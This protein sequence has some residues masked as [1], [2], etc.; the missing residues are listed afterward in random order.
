VIGVTFWIGAHIVPLPAAAQVVS[1]RLIDDATGEAVAGAQI[2]LLG[3][4][5][6]T[7]AGA[8]SSDDGSFLLRAD[9]HGWYRLRGQRLGYAT[10]TSPPLD[11]VENDRLEVEFRLA[12]E[13]IP[14]APLTVVAQSRRAEP[15]S[16]R[17]E[18]WDYYWRK[19]L[20]GDKSGFGHFLEGED[21]RSTAFSVTDMVRQVPGL[22]HRSRG[23]RNV[24]ITDR[25]G[26]PCAL[27]IDGTYVRDGLGQG[28]VN[29]TSIIAIEVYSGM[30]VPGP[31]LLARKPT[32]VVAVWTG[33]SP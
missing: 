29:P 11:L 13:A 2:A 3:P 18:R 10:T 24:V 6:R 28:W 23:G 15:R 19:D 22:Y 33:I 30:V 20:Y 4:D 25:R 14:L 12:A 21:L 31:F 7:K 27:F 9:E 26:Q 17:L 16:P 5:D 8:I 1:G 32:C